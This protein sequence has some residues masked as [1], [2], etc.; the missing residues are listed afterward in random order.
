MGKLERVSHANERGYKIIFGC[1]FVCMGGDWQVWRKTLP[2]GCPAPLFDGERRSLLAF[3]FAVEE[4]CAVI[5]ELSW[6]QRVQCPQE[7]SSCLQK[8]S[9]CR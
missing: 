4:I 6:E 8:N 5:D 2:R 7:E 3:A 9:A 1:L